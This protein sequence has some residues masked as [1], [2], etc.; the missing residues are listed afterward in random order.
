[1]IGR[2]FEGPPAAPG[3]GAALQPPGRVLIAGCGYV[4]VALASQLVASGERVLALRRSDAPLPEGVERFQADLAKPETLL[5][6]PGDIDRVVYAAAPDAST[7]DGYRR[8]YV[9][10]LRHLLAVVGAGPRLVFTS[11]TAV[12]AED[13]GGVVDEESPTAT[14]GH[15]AILLEA[16]ALVRA[17][18]GV[19]LR[20]GGI[21]G[22]GRDRMVRAVAAGT[23]RSPRVPR[24]GNR[25]H[26]DDA[27]SAAAHLLRLPAP[28]PVYIGVDLDGADL[29]TLYAWVAG[30]LGLPP[31]PL[32]DEDGTSGARPS[33]HKRCTS[34]K[35]RASGWQPAY[36]TFR[37][38]YAHALQ[39]ARRAAQ[40]APR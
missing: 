2:A 13:E 21:Y 39:A 11:S 36:P 10:G 14:S 17:A 37:E 4:G 24:Y 9:E 34:A 31:P 23:A 1:M 22:P 33:P 8:T 40:E 5:G 38:G 28:D 25:I 35:L 30:E 19:C 18:G 32:E 16:E 3:S 26:R 20:L 27:A 6:L 12:F 15:P 7:T 29:A